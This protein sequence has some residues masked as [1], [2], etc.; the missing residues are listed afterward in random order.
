M[1]VSRFCVRLVMILLLMIDTL[2]SKKGMNVKERLYVGFIVRWILLRLVVKAS[3]PYHECVHIIKLSSTVTPP[4]V[5][6]VRGMHW[7]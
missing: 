3:R 1:I 7:F 6:F 5:R 4:Y 2:K